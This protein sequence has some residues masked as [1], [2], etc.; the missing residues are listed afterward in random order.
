MLVALESYF[1]FV[2]MITVYITVIIAHLT[3]ISAL[4]FWVFGGLT[5]KKPV[6]NRWERDTD[7]ENDY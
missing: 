2:T 1:E 6:P 4:L 5:L 7:V 3:I